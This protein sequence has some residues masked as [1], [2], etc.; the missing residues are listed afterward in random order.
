MKTA[1]RPLVIVLAVAFVALIYFVGIRPR[2]LASSEL[3][4][5]ARAVGHP[6]VNVTVA[7]HSPSANEVI[8]PAS[9][10][11]LQE[12]P[13]YAR[14][15]GYLAKFLVDLGDHVTAGQPLALIDAPEVDQELNQATAALEQAAANLELA[16]SSATRWQ[17]LGA[18][19]AVAQQEVDEKV[20]ALAARQADVHAAQ[21]NVAR[22]TQLKGYQT[23]VAPFAG[24]IS[25]RNVDIGALITAGGTGRALFRLAQVGTLRVY[26]SV[27]QTYFNSVK[28]GLDV[29]VLINEF[30]GRVFPGKVVRVA[31]ALDAAT[32]TLL[33]E[34]QI[35]NE[36]GELVAGLFG[37]VRFKLTAGEPPLIIPSNAVI[38]RGDGT[39]VATVDAANTVHFAKVKLGRDFGLQVEISAGLADG[40]TVVANPSDALSEGQVVEPIAPAPAKKA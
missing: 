8:L 4:D 29:D 3:A 33:T 9:L 16:R 28:P 27:P 18:Q 30:P 21:A 25:A 5:R 20:A 13:I 23:I 38:L 2:L 35:P 11:A 1:S 14:T 39:F 34:V 10:E 36:K 15:S 24:V 19:N 12:A 37:Q 7:H 31:G 26:A 6:P 32:R 17:D 22:L 40:A